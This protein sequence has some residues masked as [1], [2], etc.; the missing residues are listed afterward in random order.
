MKLKTY[1]WYY[2]PKSHLHWAKS[3]Q[4]DKLGAQSAGAEQK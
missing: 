3:F 1:E 2:V 4:I